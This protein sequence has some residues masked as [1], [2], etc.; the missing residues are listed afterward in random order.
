MFFDS[1]SIP[2][3]SCGC[4]NFF[5]NVN[6]IVLITLHFILILFLPIFLPE[7][8]LLLLLSTAALLQCLLNLEHMFILKFDALRCQLED[9]GG[10]SSCLVVN[11]SVEETVKVVSSLVGPHLSLWGC[12]SYR[13]TRLVRPSVLPGVVGVIHV[14]IW[15]S[16]LRDS[17]DEPDLP[18]SL[19]F[20]ACVPSCPLGLLSSKYYP[21]STKSTCFLHR[22]GVVGWLH[23]WEKG[24]ARS[25]S[26]VDRLGANSLLTATYFSVS[27][28]LSGIQVLIPI[29]CLPRGCWN[30]S[31]V[32]VSSYVLVE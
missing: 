13:V 7:F 27:L 11:F 31:S 2:F 8:F 26:F 10:S 23:Q 18:V 22:L 29:L 16:W 30:V 19:F 20:S 14:A 17:W 28:F 21:I 15:A 32:H 4:Y 24:P 6:H 12:L 25:P 3:L 9:L 1:H 5:Q